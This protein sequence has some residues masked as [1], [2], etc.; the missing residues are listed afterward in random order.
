MKHRHLDDADV[1]VHELGLAALD[2]LLERGDFSDWRP[3]V[4]A[5]A[6][7]PFGPLAEKVLHICDVHPMYGTSPL[8]RTWIASVRAR[9]AAD[10]AG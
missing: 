10:P 3:L 9:A 8:W 4:R 1:P 6:A 7:D 5:I 2:D